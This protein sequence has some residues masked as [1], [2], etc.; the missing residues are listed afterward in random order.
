[1][2]VQI[3]KLNHSVSELDSSGRG[4]EKEKSDLIN[5]I[6]SLKSDLERATTALTNQKQLCSELTQKLQAS[7]SD[8]QNTKDA[9]TRERQETDK[10][11]AHCQAATQ[12]NCEA[13]TFVEG[14]Q[15]QLKQAKDAI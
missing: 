6:Q 2:K 4:K 7:E 1:L 13:S 10:L 15:M 11:R 14:L 9:L 8:C 12:Q 3:N 5:S